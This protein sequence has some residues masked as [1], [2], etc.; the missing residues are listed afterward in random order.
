MTAVLQ[1]VS[2]AKGRYDP[3]RPSRAVIP[4]FS[5]ERDTKFNSFSKFAGQRQH[6]LLSIQICEIER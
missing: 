5:F 2:D 1:F 3:Y 4:A 6:I